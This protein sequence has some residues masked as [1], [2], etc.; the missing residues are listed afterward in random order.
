LFDERR[1]ADIQSRDFGDGQ[2][3]KVD[4]EMIR[5]DGKKR[6]KRDEN[7]SAIFVKMVTDAGGDKNGTEWGCVERTEAAHGL[8]IVGHF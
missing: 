6:E 7:L 5:R 1:F 4:G 3:E 8:S 2:L